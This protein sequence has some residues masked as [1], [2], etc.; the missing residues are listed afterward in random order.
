V[1][2]RQF[3]AFVKATGYRTLA[4]RKPDPAQYPDAD[5]KLLRAGSAVFIGTRTAVPLND[6]TIWWAY[7]PGANWKRPEGPKSIVAGREEHPVVHIAHEDATAYAAWCGKR[8]PT[9]S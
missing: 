7:V 3:R 6:P 2:N 1:T 9:D 8:L 4:E 5:P